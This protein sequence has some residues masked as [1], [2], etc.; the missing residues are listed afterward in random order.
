[1]YLPQIIL[2]M[3]NLHAITESAFKKLKTFINIHTIK[4]ILVKWQGGLWLN[5][6]FNNLDSKLPELITN[7]IY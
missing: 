7:I 1:M 6:N 5:Y 2:A 4:G 3:K